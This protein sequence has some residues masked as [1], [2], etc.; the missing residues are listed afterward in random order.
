VTTH[1]CHWGGV[2]KV[3]VMGY[4]LL[5]LKVLAAALMA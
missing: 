3:A 1:G 5:R 2:G 4:C